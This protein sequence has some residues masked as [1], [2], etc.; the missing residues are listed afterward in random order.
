MST[1]T[2]PRSQREAELVLAAFAEGTRQVAVAPDTGT[3]RGDLLQMG[4]AVCAHARR[5]GCAVRSGPVPYRQF[6]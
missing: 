4:E 5:A 2:R 3:L 1:R 6:G